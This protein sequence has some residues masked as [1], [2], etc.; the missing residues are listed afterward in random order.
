MG[1]NVW[2]D[3]HEDARWNKVL[4]SYDLKSIA[5]TAFRQL[6]LDEHLRRSV[7]PKTPRSRTRYFGKLQARIVM[8]MLN[9]TK[10]ECDYRDVVFTYEGYRNHTK[11]MVIKDLRDID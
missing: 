4:L 7:N 9:E 3:S 5:A 1:G 10:F 2:Q 6:W 8:R 11:D